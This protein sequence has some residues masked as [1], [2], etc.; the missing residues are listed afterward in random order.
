MLFESSEIC[1]YLKNFSRNA[2]FEVQGWAVNT[3]YV[4]NRAAMSNESKLRNLQTNLVLRD[5]NE[6]FAPIKL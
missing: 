1:F 5:H 4:S 6:N 3:P 2:I